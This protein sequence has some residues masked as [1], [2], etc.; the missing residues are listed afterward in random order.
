MKFYR[1]QL[2]YNQRAKRIG[3]LASGDIDPKSEAWINPSS[4]SIL[5]KINGRTSIQHINHWQ[6]ANVEFWPDLT[7][8]KTFEQLMG[9]KKKPGRPAQA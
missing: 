1:C 7:D 4:M 5:T 2:Y 6:Q 8:S 9:I 3:V